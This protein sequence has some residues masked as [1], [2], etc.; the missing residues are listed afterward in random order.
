M[1]GIMEFIQEE[2]S[3]VESGILGIEM[4]RLAAVPF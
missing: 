1:D 4:D 2:G 3:S